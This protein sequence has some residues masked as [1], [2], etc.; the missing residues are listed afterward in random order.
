MPVVTLSRAEQQ[1]WKPWYAA[2]ANQARAILENVLSDDT[3][4]GFLAVVRQT[5]FTDARFESDDG[6]IQQ[7]DSNRVADIIESGRESHTREDQSI[8]LQIRLLATSACTRKHC[9]MGYTKPPSPVIITNTNWLDLHVDGLT[10]RHM[11]PVSIAAHWLHEWMHVA[12]FRHLRQD[13]DD[14]GDVPY[15]VGSL[16]LAAAM[17]SQVALEAHGENS[18]EPGTAYLEAQSGSGM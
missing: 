3:S 5:R 10:K 6:R 12:G 11:D 2:A 1:Q 4:T 8:D 14:D 18:I 17:R 16:F 15:K 13:V 7:V 9:I